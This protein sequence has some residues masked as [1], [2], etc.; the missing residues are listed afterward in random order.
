M[1]ATAGVRSTSE[2]KM[3][4]VF[5]LE[6]VEEAHLKEIPPHRALRVNVPGRHSTVGWMYL[7]MIV[8]ANEH[9][10]WPTRA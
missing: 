8:H 10:V 2:V 4:I 6:A 7:R 1:A 5:L 3:H 9:M